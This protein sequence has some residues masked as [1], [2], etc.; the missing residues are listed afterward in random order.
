VKFEK[1][2]V[3]LE[4]HSLRWH[5]RRVCC[6]VH[7]TRLTGTL[8]RAKAGVMN[9]ITCK[10]TTVVVLEECGGVTSALTHLGNGTVQVLYELE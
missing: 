7:M 5:I 1:C 3:M 4:N 2:L 8:S 10:N 9:T 6:S